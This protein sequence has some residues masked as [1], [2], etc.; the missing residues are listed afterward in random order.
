MKHMPVLAVI[1]L[2]LNLNAQQ[3]ALSEA[4]AKL[5]EAIA[6]PS[7]M[8]SIVQQLPAAEQRAYVAEANAAIAKMPGSPEAKAAS[9][10]DAN[11]AALK[12]AQRGTVTDMLA[13]IFATASLESL[14]VINEQFA[15]DVFNR[16]LNP[17][18][19]YTDEQFVKLAQ[20]ALAKIS[21]RNADVD[22]GA[23]RTG[24][25]ILMFVRASNGSPAGLADTLAAALPENVR[26][27][28]K[29]E[30]FP[31]ALLPEGEGKSYDPMLGNL[32]DPIPN[33]TVVCRL[34]H[35]Q[36]L[37]ALLD[38]LAAG[39]DKKL[40][41]LATLNVIP[42]SADRGGIDAGLDNGLYRLPFIYNRKVYGTEAGQKGGGRT[43]GGGSK[44]PGVPGGVPVGPGGKPVGPGGR[45]IEPGGYPSQY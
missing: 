16:T 19:T 10:L 42:Y 25:A 26:E 8:A 9:F 27:T 1:A 36:S 3:L 15:S 6:D 2:A 43:I 11:R 13:E 34:A 21:A 39:G 17:S 44:V 4:R 35:A 29:T 5:G 41:N 28:A 12:G 31:A 7:V 38:D 20:D 24:F 40:E 32:E 23:V 22:D 33:G 14:T 45:D 30:W 37:N 18:V